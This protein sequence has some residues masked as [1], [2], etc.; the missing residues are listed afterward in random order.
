MRIKHLPLRTR[1]FLAMILLIV[2]ASILIAAVTI[3]Q[4][5][6]QTDEYNQGRLER[7]EKSVKAAVNYWFKTGN[8]YPLETENLPYIFKDKIYEI[9]DVENLEINIYDLDGKMAI[10]SH[11]GFVKSDAPEYLPDAILKQMSLT[12]EHKFV[13]IKIINGNSF[14]SSFIYITDSKFKPIGILNI[15]YVQDNTMQ[16]KDL[17][18]FLIRMAF[19]YGLMFF[20]AIGLAYFI[21]S[22]I[23]RSIKEVTDKMTKTRLNK[24][25][26][27][28]VLKSGSTEIF[29]LVNAYNDMVD[30]L[31]ESALKLAKGEREQAWREMAKQ[32]AHEIKNP[33]TPMRLTVQSFQRRFDPNDPK[34]HDK[35]KEFSETL[36]QQIDVLNSIASAFSNFAKMPAQNK[37][38]L[39]VVDVVKHTL[40]IFTEDYIFLI[41]DK[42]EIIAKLDKTQLIRIVTNLVKNANQALDDVENKKIEVSV[43]EDNNDLVILVAD[44]GKGI[45]EE[46]KDKIFE[47]KF[48]TKTSG[49]GLGLPM[50]KNIVE[51][52]KGSVTYTTQ[53]NKGTVFKII[54][55]KN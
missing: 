44:N 36:I 45:L 22:Y 32:V 40:D 52:Y 11:G 23:T 33:L 4:Y 7:K 34:I 27:K 30:E 54:L 50:V 51:M 41:S 35:I 5:K 43:R 26:E 14:Q 13:D 1:I 18:E 6:E 12:Y 55:P 3:F 31:A 17:E 48:T 39:N 42:E 21:S 24:R 20:I 25:N 46:D 29:T 49:M 53:I 38:E 28:I 19:V 37:E 16:D 9:S 8:T 2:L 15:Q 10:S 47:P